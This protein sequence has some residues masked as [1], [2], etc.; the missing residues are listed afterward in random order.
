MPF[1][2]KRLEIPE[3]ILIEPKVFKDERGFFM[4]TYK[5]SEFRAFGIAEDFVQDNHSVS[6]RNVLR[7]LHF[8]KNPH[9]QGKLLRVVAGEIFDVAVDLRQGSPTFGRWVGADLSAE[10]KKMIYIPVGFAHGMCMLSDTAEVLYK[11]TA[12]YSPQDDAGIIWN[13]PDIGVKWP[14]KDPIISKKDAVLLR[15]KDLKDVFVYKK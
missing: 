13:D 8:Q 6:S 14:V 10:N 12:E 2:F 3:V 4:E 5:S 1:S 11:T 15:L 7:G 9:A